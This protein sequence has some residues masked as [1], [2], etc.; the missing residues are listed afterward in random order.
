[1]KRLKMLTYYVHIQLFRP[2]TPSQ[3]V[4]LILR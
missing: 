2:F 3:E 4:D 1:V